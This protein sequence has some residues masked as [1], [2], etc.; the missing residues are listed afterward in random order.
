MI[1]VGKKYNETTLYGRRKFYEVF[2]DEKL[3]P[4]G[5]KLCWSHY[6]ELL[7]V[8][9]VDAIKYYIEICE[10]NNLTKRQLHEKIKNNEYNRLS[11]ETK[12]KMISDEKLIINDLI[13]NPILIKNNSINIQISEYMLK[14]LFQ[15]V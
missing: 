11:L 15:K 8:K 14:E 2:S 12:S 13:P 1:D 6:R 7:V 4:P 10:K 9:N 3:N 5:A